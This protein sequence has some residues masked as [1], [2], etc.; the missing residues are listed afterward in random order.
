MKGR[1]IKVLRK[2]LGLTQVEFAEKLGVSFGSVNRWENE[3]RK[4]SRLA[5][6]KLKWVAKKTKVSLKIYLRQPRKI[7]WW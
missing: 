3:K 1:Q 6:E 7:R 5:M 4:P 2:N